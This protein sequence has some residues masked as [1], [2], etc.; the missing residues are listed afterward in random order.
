V[1]PLDGDFREAAE[2]AAEEAMKHGVLIRTDLDV[3]VMLVESETDL[4]LLGYANARQ[5]DTDRLKTWEVAGTAHADAHQ[6]RSIV[7]GPRNP[8]VG[9]LIGCDYP[10]NVGPHHEVVSAALH[11]VV[12]WAFVLQHDADELIAEAGANRSLFP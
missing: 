10:I 11:R 7:G 6:I 1:A 4:T 8:N 3:P 5:P 9:S 2:G 12:A